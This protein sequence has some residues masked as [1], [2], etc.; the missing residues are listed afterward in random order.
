M[1]STA[2]TQS[3]PPSPDYLCYI[4]G[5][6]FEMADEMIEHVE[7]EHAVNVPN[8][9]SDTNSGMTLKEKL[10][11]YHHDTENNL[12]LSCTICDNKFAVIKHL[13]A[14]IQAHHNIPVEDMNHVQTQP[15]LKISEFQQC[16]F[17]E[18]FFT[19]AAQLSVHT[20]DEH[21]KSVVTF[22][23]EISHLEYNTTGRYPKIAER[24]FNLNIGNTDCKMIVRYKRRIKESQFSIC[25]MVKN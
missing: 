14:H 21:V 4:C 6:S 11:K 22:D 18:N 3:S 9:V 13:I 20:A 2:S 24:T 25:V 12:I 10:A 5:K 15:V 19:C 23:E 1:Q 7:K 17:C 16:L 8:N